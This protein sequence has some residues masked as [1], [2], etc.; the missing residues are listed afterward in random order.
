MFQRETPMS[1][2]WLGLVVQFKCGVALLYC[3]FAT[4]PHLRSEAYELPSA[5]EAIRACSIV[6]AIL[7]ERWPQ[8]RCVRDAFNFL[9]R[10]VPLYEPSP[11]IATAPRRMR[12]ESANALSVLM[13]QLEAIT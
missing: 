8:S 4:P 12:R 10:E 9:S 3:F 11:Q 6:L 13:L 7:A 2:L 5:S 1:E